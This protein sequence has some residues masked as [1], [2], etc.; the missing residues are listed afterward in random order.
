[1]ALLLSIIFT[2]ERFYLEFHL[3]DG[4]SPKLIFWAFKFY[5]PV[6]IERPDEVMSETY[7]SVL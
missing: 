4:N 7:K 1:M 2:H 5:N 3:P 6:G